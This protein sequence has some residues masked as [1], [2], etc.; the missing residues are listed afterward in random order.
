MHDH[1]HQHPVLQ[2]GYPIARR[3]PKR[4]RQGSAGASRGL[5]FVKVA[6]RPLCPFIA[7][8][9]AG[10][11]WSLH[12]GRVLQDMA[13]ALGN[14]FSDALFVAGGD[15]WPGLCSSAYEARTNLILYY[16]L[17]A[18]VGSTIPRGIGT[19]VSAPLW[20]WMSAVIPSL[21]SVGSGLMTTRD[22][23]AKL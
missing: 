1:D 13:C 11:N 4:V 19:A 6:G 10:S 2:C 8:R 3:L 12:T 14:P 9:V 21:P 7:T 15:G 17:L 20:M 18:V 23:L 16:P 22:V 5:V